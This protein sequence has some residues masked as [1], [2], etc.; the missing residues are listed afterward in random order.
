MRSVTLTDNEP[1]K[2]SSS[3]EPDNSTV[4]GCALHTVRPEPTS[5]REL[6]SWRGPAA[7]VNDRPVLSSERAPKINKPATVRQ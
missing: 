5:G 3:E 2:H 4:E 7:I 6:T 1:P